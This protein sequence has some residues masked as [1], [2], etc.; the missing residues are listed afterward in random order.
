MF[1]DLQGLARYG[2]SWQ[3][4]LIVIQFA[5]IFE[6]AQG[7]TGWVKIRLFLANTNYDDD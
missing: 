3:S 4:P 1:Q 6:A 7:P 5:N 2:L